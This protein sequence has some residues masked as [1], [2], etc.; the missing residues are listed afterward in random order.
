MRD[1][2]RGDI[3]VAPPEAGSVAEGRVTAWSR[4]DGGRGMLLAGWVPEACRESLAAQHAIVHCRAGGGAGALQACVGGPMTG[5]RERRRGFVALIEDAGD[6]ADIV[7]IDLWDGA[8]A[9][10]LGADGA[11]AFG[12]AAMRAPARRPRS[13]RRSSRCVCAARSRRLS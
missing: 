2:V 10:R 6:G 3:L 5:G 7:A 4:L 8:A 12:T 11:A 9:L 13:I 1:T